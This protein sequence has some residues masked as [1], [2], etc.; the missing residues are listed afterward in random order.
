MNLQ[1][2]IEKHTLAGAVT[3]IANQ[4]SIF[5]LETFGYADLAEQKPIR[6]DTLIRIASTTKPIIATALMIPK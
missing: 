2:L 3:L 1:P 6:P 4:E 5:S